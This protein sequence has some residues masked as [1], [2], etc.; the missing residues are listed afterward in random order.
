MLPMT[1][2]PNIEAGA[3][4]LRQAVAGRTWFH[5]ID[6]GNGVRTPGHK[7]TAAEWE[8]LH[9]PDLAGRS[10]LDV[11]AYD[12]FF[13]FEAERRGA[14]RVVASDHWV[15][16][17]PGSDARGNF[18]LAWRTLGSRVQMRDIPVEEISPDTL[19][20]TFDVVLFLG[21]LY[22]APDP[23]G[24]LRRVRSVTTG[25]AVVETAV[26]LLEVPIPAAAYYAGAS[27]NG[28]A[29][30]AGRRGDAARCR[31]LSNH[32]VPAVDREQGVGHPEHRRTWFIA[33]ASNTAAASPAQRP[34]GLSCPRLARSRIG[35]DDGS[36]AGELLVRDPGRLHHRVP[37]V[38]I[39]G[40]VFVP[41][42]ARN[43][44]GERQVSRDLPEGHERD[45][46]H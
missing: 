18:E 5:T 10:V 39:L 35:A 7:D 36:E 33:A 34:D 14:A 17:W 26:D 9:L 20:A 2:D 8:H 21:V 22:H 4:E 31:I 42:T 24:Y 19:G 6:L 43:C 1:E 27:L 28:D 3:A 45:P 30:S 13:S 25:I 44:S 41:M 29:Q 15:W 16:N 37:R 40:G 23:V 32:R 12:G 46:N 11:G 38:D